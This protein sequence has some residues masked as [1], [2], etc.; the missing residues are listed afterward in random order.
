MVYIP[1]IPIIKPNIYTRYFISFG[2]Q[3]C[4]CIQ[5]FQELS[6]L[7]K[8]PRSCEGIR[9]EPTADVCFLN[10]GAKKALTRCSSGLA[11][12]NLQGMRFIAPIPLLES[13]LNPKPLNPKPSLLKASSG[14]SRLCNY[15]GGTVAEAALNT[16]AMDSHS[17]CT[18]LGTTVSVSMLL[19]QGFVESWGG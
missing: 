10:L 15:G 16:R 2:L 14:H 8:T 13:S 11:A 17:P 6:K 7:N 12:S 3:R 18:W 19:L 9:T 4:E 5:G 1:S